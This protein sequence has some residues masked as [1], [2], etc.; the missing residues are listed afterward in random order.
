MKFGKNKGCEF[1]FNECGKSDNPL[2]TF[3]NEFYLPK[4]S[5]INIEPSCSSGRLSKTIYKLDLIPEDELN[6][7][8]ETNIIEYITSDNKGGRKSTNYCPI[9]Q[10]DESIEYI[11]SCSNT[12]NTNINRQREEKYGTNIF[13]SVI[14]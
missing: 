12:D 8:D 13:L 14:K 5:T 9:A 6:D 3:A 4:E 10:Y 2:T 11:G 1:Y 7:N